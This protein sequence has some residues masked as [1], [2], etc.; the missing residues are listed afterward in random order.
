MENDIHRFI[1]LVAMR[2]TLDEAIVVGAARGQTAEQVRERYLNVI[3]DDVA[4]LIGEAR[5]HL[6]QDDQFKHGGPSAQLSAT[7]S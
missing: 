2:L 6:P 7:L 3:A 5:S 1:Q 4:Y